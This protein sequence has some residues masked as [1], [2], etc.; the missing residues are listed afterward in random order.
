MNL[1]SL[2]SLDSL[3]G[4][5]IQAKRRQEF[6][7]DYGFLFVGSGKSYKL[8][9]SSKGN[10]GTI[11]T[12]HNHLRL[13]L[14]LIL[15]REGSTINFILH[16]IRNSRRLLKWCSIQIENNYA[17]FHQ[18]VRLCNGESVFLFYHESKAEIEIR[19]LTSLKKTWSLD[20]TQMCNKFNLLK[21]LD[22][23]K[24]SLDFDSITHLGKIVLL[25][26][27]K[28]IL[29]KKDSVDQSEVVFDC[30]ELTI[31][32]R[33][34]GLRYNFEQRILL[35][36]GMTS[37]FLFG[38]DD[39]GLSYSRNIG[40]NQLGR[41]IRLLGW[42]PKEEF[43]LIAQRIM[44]DHENYHLIDYRTSDPMIIN[45][46]NGKLLLGNCYD[47]INHRLFYIEIGHDQRKEIRT[48]SFRDF[49]AKYDLNEPQQQICE[50]N[51]DTEHYTAPPPI[52]G[53]YPYYF[54]DSLKGTLFFKPLRG[55]DEKF[56]IDVPLRMSM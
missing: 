36:I 51:F 46:L 6:D 39:K 24:A 43:I 35:V 10:L 20:L 48:V 1:I 33:L 31:K 4:L 29:V 44:G 19:S 18:N 17:N 23:I 7:Q 37:F 2:D 42:D 26:A 22:Q 25:L 27:N 50:I 45:F 47:S 16:S 38:F 9:W 52:S 8:R 41:A 34:M 21:Y 30:S 3:D 5:Q 56:L 13:G 55:T 15:A 28:L 11:L 40:C 49:R 32:E 12:G 53:I 14:V 54:M